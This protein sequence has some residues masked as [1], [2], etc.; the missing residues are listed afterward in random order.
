[1]NFTSLLNFKS[2]ILIISALCLAGVNCS[3]VAECKT[4]KKQVKKLFSEATSSLQSNFSKVTEC[5]QTHLFAES[6]N[7]NEYQKCIQKLNLKSQYES[8]LMYI[9]DRGRRNI[10]EFVK[11]VKGYTES[12][13]EVLNLEFRNSPREAEEVISI[14]A[15]F[16]SAM[17][18]FYCS[19]GVAF[20]ALIAF[21]V[22]IKY[23][24]GK[25]EENLINN[26]KL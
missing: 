23:S 24:H 4:D 18:V 8:S 19:I 21:T 2:L 22:Y 14:S 11:A 20:T 26:N 7:F 16:V 10:E 5:A 13:C 12:Y 9:E 25:E 6:S 3:F 1:M 15:S 17:T